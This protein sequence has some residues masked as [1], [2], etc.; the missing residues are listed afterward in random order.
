MK[1]VIAMLALAPGSFGDR[2]GPNGQILEMVADAVVGGRLVFA[3]HITEQKLFKQA[4]EFPERL[5]ALSAITPFVFSMMVG[6]AEQPMLLLARPNPRPGHQSTILLTAVRDAEG[7]F[8]LTDA[9]K[10][11]SRIPHFDDMAT[12]LSATLRYLLTCEAAVTTAIS[13][14]ETTNR[15]VEFSL[16]D[17]AKAIRLKE[18]EKAT[19]APAAP[20]DGGRPLTLGEARQALTAFD[21]LDFRRLGAGGPDLSFVLDA[22]KQAKA[23]RLFVIETLSLNPDPSRMGDVEDAL[24]SGALRAPFPSTFILAIREGLSGACLLGVFDNGFVDDKTQGF[25]LRFGFAFPVRLDDGA[26][27]WRRDL[28]RRCR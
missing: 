3:G 28:R 23:G 13:I 26:I 12:V 21:E 10:L 7:R 14:E 27:G 2:F 4:A 8:K 25:G 15:S 17:V 19:A 24:K 5:P 18:A 20:T 9:S 22:A 6:G 1:F 11:F 16:L